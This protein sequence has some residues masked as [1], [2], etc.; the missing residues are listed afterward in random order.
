MTQPGECG[1]CAAYRAII[2]ALQEEIARLNSIINTAAGFAE[3]QLEKP[4]MSR[5][6]ALYLTAVQLREQAHG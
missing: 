5:R 6:N 2:A 1:A 3:L 4:T